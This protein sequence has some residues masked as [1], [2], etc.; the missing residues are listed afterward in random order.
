MLGNS[1]V[2]DF[3][4]G[5]EAGFSYGLVVSERERPPS[6]LTQPFPSP[7]TQSPLLLVQDSESSSWTSPNGMPDCRSVV[8]WPLRCVLY[9]GGNRSNVSCHHAS[10]GFAPVRGPPLQR[11]FARMLWRLG[12]LACVR[13]SLC[14]G[15]WQGGELNILSHARAAAARHLRPP[16]VGL[17]EERSSNGPAVQGAGQDGPSA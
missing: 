5:A 6:A 8:F 7:L 16:S 10:L 1:A 11:A 3:S 2:I 14:Y 17:G 9:V 4:T 12:R 15:E 13:R